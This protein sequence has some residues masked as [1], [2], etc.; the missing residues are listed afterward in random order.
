MDSSKPGLEEPAAASWREQ[1]GREILH[2]STHLGPC[3]GLVCFDD[4]HATNSTWWLRTEGLSPT[5]SPE[6]A[7]WLPYKC[8]M[9]P[10]NKSDGREGVGGMLAGVPTRGRINQ[11]YQDDVTV[12]TWHGVWVVPSTMEMWSTS[13]PPSAIHINNDDLMESCCAEWCEGPL[14][15]Q[16]NGVLQL[17]IHKSW[18]IYC[19][20]PVPSSKSY[21]HLPE[22]NLFLETIALP[23][24]LLEDVS[25]CELEANGWFGWVPRHQE[26]GRAH[27]GYA[28][29]KCQCLVT[30]SR[31]KQKDEAADKQAENSLL[32]S[33]DFGLGCVISPERCCAGGWKVCCIEQDTLQ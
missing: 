32:C 20:Q 30:L 10:A 21:F 28:W 26:I 12:M 29:K 18:V 5:P 11:Y 1:Q 23:M 8:S 9:S 25:G 33:G 4:H 14:S 31:G 19:M 16:M 24:S 7:V 15:L 27:S 22:V 13:R 3:C 6:W 17:R 2:G